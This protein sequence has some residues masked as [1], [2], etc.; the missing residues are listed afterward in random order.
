MILPTKHLELDKSLLAIG[1]VILNA[2]PRPRTVTSVW[3]EVRRHEGDLSFESFSL[4]M[5]FLY[6]IGVVEMADEMI[7]SVRR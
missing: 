6:T 1:G 3:E 2:L 4:D 5:A 7:R